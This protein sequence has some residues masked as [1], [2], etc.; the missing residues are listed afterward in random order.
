M[1][2]WRHTVAGA[3]FLVV[4]VAVTVSA[5]R[6]AFLPVPA[7]VQYFP[8]DYF[9][10]KG[11]AALDWFVLLHWPG[12]EQL[13]EMWRSKGLHEQERVALLL[14]GAAFH[15]PILL[16]AYR[17]ALESPNARIREAAA[18][19]FR[20]LLAAPLPVVEAGVTP[21]VAQRFEWELA[22]VE[23]QLRRQSLAGFWLDRLRAPETAA[24][25]VYRHGAAIRALDAI[26]RP[27]DLPELIRGYESLRSRSDRYALLPV[28]QAM[29]CRHMILVP[30]GQRTGWGPYV[31]DFAAKSLA[32]WMRVRCDFSPGTVLRASLARYGM[33]RADPMSQQACPVWLEVLRHGPAF[34][35]PLASRQLY[36]CGGPPAFISML[37]PSSK[38]ARKRREI[39]L[40]W[41]GVRFGG[42]Q[43]LRG[44]R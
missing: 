21:A 35:W 20:D 22:A 40:K 13:L 31:F 32:R 5:A 15:D 8:G 43:R 2:K 4:F 29:T 34:D 25:G 12:P 10:Q 24:A 19:G 14:G 44:S 33:S 38:K 18:F 6:P 39:I 9:R 23:R 16:P 36:R 28:M 1:V 41:F 7:T 37:H 11:R 26:L 42:P 27:E 17:E 30:R 3:V